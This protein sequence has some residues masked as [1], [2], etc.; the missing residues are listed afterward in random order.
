MGSAWNYKIETCMMTWCY[1]ILKLAMMKSRGHKL[2]VVLCKVRHHFKCTSV[3]V[4]YVCHLLWSIQ[5]FKKICFVLSRQ[6]TG[7]PEQET[8]EMA[9]LFYFYTIYVCMHLCADLCAL[10]GCVCVPTILWRFVIKLV[11]TCRARQPIAVTHT[12]SLLTEKPP[13]KLVLIISILWACLSAQNR[14]LSHPPQPSGHKPHQGL[15]ERTF[16]WTH[17]P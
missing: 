7:V 17:W 13:K 9:A 2:T 4:R 6:L 14:H 10:W 8:G 15:T 3:N 16:W 12:P 5:L 1:R 11:Q